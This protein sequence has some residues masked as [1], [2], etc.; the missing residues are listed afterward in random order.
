MVQV[1]AML[2]GTPVV[3]SDMPGVRTAV[4]KTGFGR[5]AKKRDSQDLAEKISDLL[6]TP[7]VVDP[8]LLADFNFERI[9]DEYEKVFS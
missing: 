5:L 3:A 8:D 7:A 6:K 1:E 9:I 2:C 4:Q